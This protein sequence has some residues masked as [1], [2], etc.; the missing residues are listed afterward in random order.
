MLGVNPC[1]IIGSAARAI[2]ARTF[3]LQDEGD[4]DKC[5][6]GHEAIVD[7]LIALERA[8]RPHLK[9]ITA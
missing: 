3:R 2:S 5:P 8:L 4:E 7:A 6:K 9:Q 1:P